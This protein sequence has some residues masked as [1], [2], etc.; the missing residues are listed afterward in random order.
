MKITAVDSWLVHVPFKEDIHWASGK[1]SGVTRLVTRI[2]TNAGIVGWGE[3]ISLIDA[4]PAVFEKVVKPLAIGY[5]VASV[6]RFSRHVLGAGYYHHK[7]AAVM[8][9]AGLEMAMWDALGKACQQPLHRLWG[10]LFREKV[11]AAAYLFL[12][13]PGA[14]AEKAAW[15]ADQGYAAFKVKIG[16]SAERDVA[17]VQALRGR[18]GADAHIRADVNGAWYPGT[19]R[20]ILHSLE[21]FDLAYVEQPLPV[22]DVRGHARLRAAQAVPIAIDEGAYTLEEIL[23]IVR[24]DAADVVLLDPHESGGL[25]QTLKAGGLTEAANIPVT[26]HSGA[27]LGLSQAAY[28]HLAASMPNM[29]LAIDTE[30]AYLAG[31]VVRNPPLLEDGYFTVPQGP[32]LGVEPD[33]SLLEQYAVETIPCAYLDP[34]RP[35]WFSVK[36]AY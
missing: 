4:V 28:L 10:G 36:P 24:A 12:P 3:T 16:Y 29:V 18:L 27:E 6:E 19:A 23:E 7:R 14:C 20:R 22:E 17:I 33:I 9:M 15:F 35:G 8:A 1:R 26:L 30:R 34:D 5:P 11:A 21:P 13:D 32:G 25:W 2:T 31:D